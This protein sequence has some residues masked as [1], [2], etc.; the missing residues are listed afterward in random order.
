LNKTRRQ[1]A[2]GLSKVLNLGWIALSLRLAAFPVRIGRGAIRDFLPTRVDLST[3]FGLAA[4]LGM[5]H[6]TFTACGFY[7][8]RRLATN[9][10]LATEGLKATTIIAILVAAGAKLFRTPIHPAS[11]L[12]FWVLASSLVVGTS[13]LSRFAVSKIRR[14]GRNLRY[15]MILGTNPRAVE[16]AK[17]LESRRELGYRIVGFVD[18][19]WAGSAD[20]VG[21]TYKHC[22]DFKGLA[23]FLRWNVVDEVAFY[24]PLRSFYGLSSEVAALCEHHGII[25]RFGASIFDLKIAQ[26]GVDELGGDHHLTAFAGSHAVWSSVVKR[27]IDIIISATMLILLAPLLIVIAVAVKLTS[28]GPAF[29]LQERVGLNKRRFLI[30][31]FRTMVQNAETL[32]AGLET[33]NEVSGPVFKIKNDPRMTPCGSFLRRTSL[34]ELPQLFNVLKG[35]M[36]LVG[37]RPLPV[38][39]YAGFNEDWQRRRFSVRPGITCL[40]Q[41]NG[42]SS[43]P[44]DRWME[45]D[46]EYLD[47]WS[48]WLDLKILARTI[49]AVMKGSGAA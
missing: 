36:S 26:S 20:F 15:L 7:R 38:R 34:D 46:I 4:M 18:E 9:G 30:C 13:L 21:T 42:R 43:L 47:R 3:V 31:K 44:F 35:D 27:T 28:P 41:V 39:D 12:L 49:P 17:R 40:W 25:M 48:L 19:D 10:T 29:F 11:L 5:C 32:L 1:F 14:R 2:L 22:S 37:P 33:L 6:L 16:F 24:L 45:L 23:E 8:S